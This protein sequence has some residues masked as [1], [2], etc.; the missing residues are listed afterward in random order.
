MNEVRLQVEELIVLS[1]QFGIQRGAL[2]G[3]MG[4]LLWPQAALGAEASE[5]FVVSLDQKELVVNLGTDQGLVPKSKILLFRRLVVMHPYSKQ[6]IV[7]RFPIGA[8]I[9]DEVGKRLSIIRRWNGLSRAPERGDIAVFQ[10]APQIKKS[11]PKPMTVSSNKKGMAADIFALHNVFVS[12]LGEPIDNRIIAYQN[13]IKGFPKSQLVDA[14]GAEIYTLREF[15]KSMR[16]PKAA[17]LKAQAPT[18]PPAIKARSAKPSPITVGENLE[19]VIAVSNPEVIDQVSLLLSRSPAATSNRQKA[20]GA[21]GWKVIK[22][23]RD[24]DYYYRAKLPAELVKEPGEI[25]YFI[26][27]VR[28]NATFEAIHKSASSPGKITVNNP[29]AGDQA[30]GKTQVSIIGRM[31]DFN[32]PGEATDG[33]NQFETTISY[34]VNYHNLRAVRFGIGS[35]SGGCT[36]SDESECV[37]DWSGAKKKSDEQRLSLNYA[38]AEAEIGGQWIGFAGRLTG[39]NHQG[40]VGNT[41]RKANG[42]EV[43]A[44]IGELQKTRLVLG[45]ATLDDLGSKGF[46]DAHIE[47]LEKVPLKAGVVVTSLPVQSKD[48]GVQL[49]AQAGYRI[50]DMLSLQS[51]FGWNLR[52]I[53][54]Y[55]FTL[56]GGLGLEW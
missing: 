31:V 52:T 45:V 1:R 16:S 21:E 43:R 28:K 24:G 4:L 22:M 30:P 26:E 56:G 49:S 29:L 20:K 55:G 9:P 39:G 46:L 53:N 17:D 40:G 41:A 35:L 10:I 48:W 15:E 38:F 50:T 2:I 42:F 25:D 18:L 27:A 34:D 51:L 7:D 13:F 44:R 37:D 23:S 8:V 19:I 12:T 6:P 33:Y 36:L 3:L 54:H 47:V 5:G 14:V 11:R 32:Q